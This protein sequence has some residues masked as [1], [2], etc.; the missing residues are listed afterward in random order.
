MIDLIKRL[1]EAEVGSAE[2]SAHVIKAALAPAE[3]WVAQSPFNGAWLIYERREKPR[4]WEPGGSLRN[5]SPTES[6][7]AALALAERVL[8]GWGWCMRTDDTGQCFANVFPKCPNTDRI[9]FDVYAATPALALC[10]A[11]LKA[12]DTGRE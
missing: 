8:P 12:T 4:L 5:L 3:T 10:A 7:D 1:K 6:L 2:L 9:Y 11:I